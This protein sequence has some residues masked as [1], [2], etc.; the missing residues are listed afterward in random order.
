MDIIEVDKK[1]LLFGHRDEGGNNNDNNDNTKSSK[2][3]DINGPSDSEISVKTAPVASPKDDNLRKLWIVSGFC[4]VFMIIEVI[5]GY[6][7]SSIAVMADAAHL[8]SDLL[9]FLISIASIY[10]SR[11]DATN[12]MSYGF[13][14]AEVIG[15]MV[16]I[17]IIWGLTIWLVYEAAQRVVER[18]P[19][20]GFIMV[21]TA[22]IGFVFNVTMGLVLTYEGIDHKLHEHHDHEHEDYAEEEEEENEDHEHDHN[23]KETQAI[24][25][26]HD[27][28]NHEGHDQL[29]LN[30][31][32]ISHG[33]KPKHGDVNLRAAF[34]HVIGDAIQN[35]GVVVAGLIIYFWPE[36]SI[37]D[38]I[39]TFVFSIIII[40]TTIRILRECIAVLMEGS[41]VEF[42]IDKLKHDLKRVKGVI[43]V[44]DLHV[45]SLS[46]GK[47]SLSCHLVSNNP[48]VS[49]AKANKLIRKK[50]NITHSTIQ[51][52]LN[53][54]V[55][56]YDCKHD[57][58]INN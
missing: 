56:N 5:G 48:Q 8:L 19:V 26:M 47:L 12:Q 10:I 30:V 51:V 46:V 50:Y 33:H 20:N 49:L 34:I 17:N 16:S 13:H 27:D 44:H 43:E 55:N 23:R 57:L 18:P 6:L 41:P 24:T 32:S 54:K 15:A 21:I 53:D 36:Y 52:E 28:H 3:I 11:K 39:C 2:V 35:F 25:E 29:G 42:N 14:R 40:F 45:W 38:P 37:A 58:H 22:I 9:G 1:P 31:P 7:A 4:L